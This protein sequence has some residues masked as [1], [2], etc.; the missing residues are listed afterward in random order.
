MLRAARTRAL[1]ASL[2]VTLAGCAG[3]RSGTL[4]EVPKG[5]V[6][7]VFTG[8][9][10]A[11][12]DQLSGR[13]AVKLRDKI[14][15]EHRRTY[16]DDGHAAW[17]FH[18]FD[19]DELYFIVARW[20]GGDVVGGTY[21]VLTRYEVRRTRRIEKALGVADEIA[22]YERGVGKVRAGM[23]LHEV[24]DLRGAP[25]HVIQLGPV[26]AFDYVYKDLCVRFLEGRAAH[27]WPAESCRRD[28]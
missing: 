20:E 8:L 13:E 24:Q 25:D 19:E 17:F 23:S 12:S 7:V 27:L 5:L 3:S 15:E 4:H 2:A 16:L 9:D 11:P 1:L 26:G 21:H 28:D 18:A 6:H 22:E 10:E 14:D